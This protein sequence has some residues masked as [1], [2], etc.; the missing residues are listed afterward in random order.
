MNSFSKTLL[1]GEKWSAYIAKGK[2]ITFTTTEDNANLSLLIYNSKNTSE[3]YNMP[4]T[5]KSQDTYFLSKNNV[6]LSDCGRVMASIISDTCGWHDCLCGHTTRALTDQKYGQKTYQTC[7]NDFYRCGEENFSIELLRNGMST[8]DLTSCI[9]LFSKTVVDLDGSM[10]FV[11]SS[12][13]GQSVTFRTEMNLFLITSN[14]P[15]PLDTS[16]TY[17][18]VPIEITVCNGTAYD[19]SID[20]SVNYNENIHRA[21]EN[22]WDYLFLMEN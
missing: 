19:T 3:R 17:P 12:K 14:T 10:T 13:K 5:L 18:S 16:L 20:A 9:N 11:K 6:L 15:N 2:N 1:P 22:T 4:D 8:S 7:H 21:F